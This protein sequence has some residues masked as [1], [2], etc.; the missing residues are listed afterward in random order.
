MYNNP[1]VVG[2]TLEIGHVCHVHW[3]ILVVAV[4]GVAGIYVGRRRRRIVYVIDLADSAAM[5]I[6][7]GLGTCYLDFA[8]LVMGIAALAVMTHQSKET[9]EQRNK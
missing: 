9:A 4:V 6:L 1:Q 2:T 8:A 5:I 7:S 3:M